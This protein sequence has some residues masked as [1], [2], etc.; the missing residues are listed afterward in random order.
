M[1]NKYVKRLSQRKDQVSVLVGIA[2]DFLC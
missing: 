1:K 2:S